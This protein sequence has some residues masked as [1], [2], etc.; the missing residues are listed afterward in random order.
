MPYISVVV[1]TMRVGGLDI[2][3]TGLHGQTFKDFELVLVDGLY[4]KRKDIV[5]A[6]KRDF[7]VKHVAPI[8]N[9]FPINSFCRYANTGLVHAR[10]QIVVF[11]VDYTWLPPNALEQHVKFHT[12]HSVTEPVGLMCPHQY[13][14]TP[15]LD[16]DFKPYGHDDTDIYA[17]DCASGKLD[18]VMWS[19]F[20]K[21]WRTDLTPEL[22]PDTMYGADPKLGLPAGSLLPSY[23]HGKNESIRLEHALAINGWDEDLDGT[24][25]WQDSDFSDRLAIKLGIQWTIVP[26]NI[27]YIVN[28]RHVFP[29]AKRLR[30]FQ[31]NYDVWQAKKTAGYPPVNNWSII[32]TWNTFA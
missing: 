11:L 16:P 22:P 24:H 21:E 17:A 23:F 25:G 20:N 13:L 12:G 18:S 2:L 31:S 10:G 8:N 6:A 5:Q 30:P 29:F 3:F 19:I 14:A 26:H 28:P 15:A 9:P 7:N 32:D 1:P 4:D 27:A